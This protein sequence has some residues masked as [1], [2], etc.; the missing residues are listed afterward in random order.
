MINKIKRFTWDQ[1]IENLRQLISKSDGNVLNDGQKDAL[2]Y[3]AG[4]LPYNGVILADEV[5]LGKTR[6]AVAIAKAVMDAGGRVAILIPPGLGYQWKAEF[7][8]M[9]V[10]VADPIRSLDSI[11]LPWKDTE[12]AH[13]KWFEQPV[14]LISHLFSNWHHRENSRDHRFWLLPEM[15]AQWRKAHGGSFPRNYNGNFDDLSRKIAKDVLKSISK[16]KSDPLRRQLNEL[17]KLSWSL[18]LYDA[19][20]YTDHKKGKQFQ[21]LLKKCIGAVLGAFDLIIIDEAHKARGTETGLSKS[22][23]EI[24]C[25]TSDHKVLAL[26]ATPVELEDS[27]WDDLL[28]RVGVKEKIKEIKEFTKEVE[29]VTKQWRNE[30]AAQKFIN[31]ARNFE[32]SLK[33]YLV[34]RT[35]LDDEVIQEFSSKTGQEKHTYRKEIKVAINPVDG[36][37]PLIWC[38]SVCAVE[39]LSFLTPMKDDNKTK[40]S[41]LT[42]ASGHG[43]LSYF[44]NEFDQ[45]EK[46]PKS[47]RKITDSGDASLKKKAQRI[48]YWKKKIKNVSTQKNIYDHPGWKAIIECIENEYTLKGQKVLVFGTYIKPMRELVGLLNA[49]EMIR[50]L[51]N[52]QYWPKY[53]ISKSEEKITEVALRQ[54]KGLKKKWDLL[55]IK[56]ALEKNRKKHEAVR[57]KIRQNFKSSLDSALRREKTA[58]DLSYKIWQNLQNKKNIKVINLLCDAS[59]ELINGHELWNKTDI[60]GDVALRNYEDLLVSITDKDKMETSG[61]ELYFDETQLII[62]ELEDRLSEEYGGQT[63]PFAKLLY[64]ETKHHTRRLIQLAFNREKSFP[65]VLFAQTKVGREGLNLHEACKTVLLIHPEWNPA[66]VEQ[67]IGRVDRLGSLWA[68]E[69]REYI[70]ENKNLPC[71]EFRPVIFEQTYDEQNWNVLQKRWNN[72]KAQLHGII[73]PPEIEAD[74]REEEKKLIRNINANAPDFRPPKINRNRHS[75]QKNKI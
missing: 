17:E 60:S 25:K 34:R 57:K 56:T 11:Y 9:E 45:D 50:R 6:I 15:Y 66:A 62:R 53:T 42:F 69:V 64:G 13:K 61:T 18:D 71:I 29:S 74:A 32:K 58:K 38:K 1:T 72:L 63:S 70:S 35:K 2:N 68:K 5:G 59:I 26:T 49:R 75:Y 31:A 39:S 54:M 55:E 28:E 41:R 7:K 16:T 36:K 52:G 12:I 65:T 40:R 3:I 67:Q 51:D 10:D 33:P 37:L 43:L 44:D 47:I 14:L 8:Q 73:I 30:E 21:D 4:R 48:E 46:F 24:F 27:D 22:L 23:N 19:D 20:V